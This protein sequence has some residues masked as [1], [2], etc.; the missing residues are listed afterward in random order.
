MNILT[1]IVSVLF[2]FTILQDGCE[3][4]VLQRRVT[5]RFRLSSL[6]YMTTWVLWSSVARKMRSG[7]RRDLYLS[8]FGPLSLLLLLVFFFQA[9]DG[10]RDLTVTGVQTCA[11]PI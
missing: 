6:F 5:R 2:I 8:Y 7:N 4:V 3:P 10:I 11:L 9:E 1:I